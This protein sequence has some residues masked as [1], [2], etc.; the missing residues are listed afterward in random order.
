MWKF[1]KILKR[2]KLYK[3]RFLYEKWSVESDPS[4]GSTHFCDYLKKIKSL[5][6]KIIFKI[7]II[8]TRWPQMLRAHQLLEDKMMQI[9]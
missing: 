3:S 8:G 1:W 4:V 2:K 5:A 9:M 6:E 7:W